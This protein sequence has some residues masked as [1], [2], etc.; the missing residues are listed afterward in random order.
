VHIGSFLSLWE[1]KSLRYR[2]FLSS[3]GVRAGPSKSDSKSMKKYLKVQKNITD[4]PQAGMEPSKKGAGG[5]Y[6]LRA[7]LF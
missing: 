4:S 5:F 6:G 7:W 3:F 2:F 1:R